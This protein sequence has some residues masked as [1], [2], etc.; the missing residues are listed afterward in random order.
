MSNDN[1]RDEVWLSNN[2]EDS[3]S[4]TIQ[5]SA[6]KLEHS[7]IKLGP[8]GMELCAS[9]SSSESRFSPP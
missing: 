5:K 7:T 3:P 4:A 6:V 2:T 9:T 1:D 8:Y